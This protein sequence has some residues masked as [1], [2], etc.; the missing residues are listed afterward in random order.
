MGIFIRED[1]GR[2]DDPI[3]TYR[4]FGDEELASGWTILL[5]IMALPFVVVFFMLK[6]FCAFFAS[7]LIVCIS[8][9]L[10]FALAA[11]A[12]LYRRCNYRIT[13]IAATI[14]NTLPLLNLLCFYCVPIMIN[15]SNFENTVEFVLTVFVCLSIEI[16]IMALARV[17]NSSGKHMIMSV[18]FIIIASLLLKG[19]TSERE[20]CTLR[21]LQQLYF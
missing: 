6:S 5:F 4:Y 13:G 8:V 9:Y 11:G 10:I 14:I 3:Q 19:L 12:F 21:A 17:M 7:H 18:I 2:S 15:E 16:F 1:Y 20:E